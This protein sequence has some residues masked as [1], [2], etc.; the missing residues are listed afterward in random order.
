MRKFDYYRADSFEDAAEALRA[1]PKLQVLAGGTDLLA[2]IKDEIFEEKEEA[3]IDIKSIEGADYVKEEDGVLKIGAL[4]KLSHLAEDETVKADYNALAE[5]AYSIASPLVRNLGTIGGN[6]CQDVRCWYYRYPHAVGDRLNCRRKGG[7]I[8]YA[9]QGRNRFHS[10]YGG[11]K[12]DGV[13]SCTKGC[14]ASTEIPVYMELL[15]KGDIDGAAKVIMRVNPIPMITGRVCAHFC[16]DDCNHN[17]YGEAVQI[18]N[19]ERFLG[20]HILENKD[21]FYE[22]TAE[23]T[24]KK[25]AIVGSGP[26][27][28]SAAYYLR[29]AGN[30]VTIY[31][32]KEEAGGML[33]Y[34]IPAY[35]LPKDIV[36]K[37]IGIYEDMGVKFILNT[38]VG[39]DIT[40]AELEEQYDTVCY[41]TGAWKRP[42]LGLSG[43]ELTVFGLEFLEQVHDWMEGKIGQ[44]VLVTGG[45]NVA[46][47]VAV[48]AKRLGAKKVYMACLESEEEMP[49][50]P[51][52]IARAR[53]EGIEIMPSWGLSKVISEGDV[54][55][56]M[57]LMRCTSVRD[58]D[59][60]FNPQYDEDEKTVVNC[61]N[62]LMAVGQQVD[63]SFLGDKYEMQLS[64]G[65]I[66]VD[67]E[68]QKTSREGIFAAGDA[69]TGPK[70]IILAIAN[71]HVAAKGMNKYLGV[72]EAE[73]KTVSDNKFLT[74]DMDGIKAE[75][76][77][78]L[79][80]VPLEERGIDVEDE[81]SPTK[82]E[83]LA[84]AGRCMDCGCYSV[85]PSDIAPA[86]IAAG[87]TIKTTKRDIDAEEFACTTLKVSNVLDRDELVT[88]IDIPIVEGVETHYDK[89][90]LRNAIDWAIVSLASALKVENGVFSYVRL[91]LGGVAPVPVR[92]KAVEEFLTGKAIEKDVVEEACKI[93]TADCIPM[94]ENKYKI[95]EIKGMIRQAVYRMSDKA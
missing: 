41:A 86:L 66:E 9:I 89:F 92:L 5:A 79:K 10:I 8:C 23:D 26:A 69:T 50:S 4:A 3:L 77:L 40:P 19:V 22:V 68:T 84:E 65:L 7:E 20:D 76:G 33:M 49:A 64:R 45:G 25:I 43:E 60:R 38:R 51:G 83:A 37:V 17:E 42:V 93:A 15:R 71:G 75:E 28:L 30:D 78:K 94:W 48:T 58:E 46:M 24:G 72:A 90:R 11:M 87:A 55:K 21:K 70:T 95:E 35:R 54:V 39:T 74:F 34:A 27:G 29:K 36:R 57:E 12:C 16:Q 91:V 47:D 59:G 56:G 80:E 6:I 31:D 52:E 63:L 62:I 2:S 53:E 61:E 67:E 32:V 85:A 18:R 88:E 82:E 1:K 14:P 13:A 44:E 81:F 73:D